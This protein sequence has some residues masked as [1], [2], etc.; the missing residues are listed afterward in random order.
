[1]LGRIGRVES[2][3]KTVRVGHAY[4]NLVEMLK[5][6][7]DDFRCKRQRGDDS[8]GSDRAI[9]GACGNAARHVIKK[10]TLD[11]IDYVSCR[12]GTFTRRQP[13][14]VFA[15]AS[16]PERVVYCVLLL[17][18]RCPAGVLEVIQSMLAHKVVL[19]APKV[20]PYMRELVGEERARM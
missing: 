18:I 8:P 9:I 7:N 4:F 20:Y 15:I 2:S 1:M 19:D 14:A 5:C 16:E 11:S 3:F 17:H 6:W 13:P 10:N 12:A